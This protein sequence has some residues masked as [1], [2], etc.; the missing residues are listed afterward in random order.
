MAAPIIKT[1]SHLINPIETEDIMI[2]L[3]PATASPFTITENSH[4]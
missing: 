3:V 4:V 2:R 1:N